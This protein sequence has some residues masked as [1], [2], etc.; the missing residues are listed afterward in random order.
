MRGTTPLPTVGKPLNGRQGRRRRRS[1]RTRGRPPQQGGWNRGDRGGFRHDQG[2]DYATQ[3][4]QLER[5]DAPIA[6]Y[7]PR[8]RATIGEIHW[9]FRDKRLI[10]TVTKL[11]LKQYA[12]SPFLTGPIHFP[13]PIDVPGLYD[14]S[15]GIQGS[16]QTV[17]A[18][19]RAKHV[20]AFLEDCSLDIEVRN[21]FNGDEF[22]LHIEGLRR[23]Q[24]RRARKILAD[25]SVL[26]DRTEIALPRDDRFTLEKLPTLTPAERAALEAHLPPEP[27]DVAGMAPDDSAEED[28]STS[29]AEFGV[30]E[31]S[32]RLPERPLR[33]LDDD[34]DQ[35][36]PPFER[37]TPPAV[38]VAPVD[39]FGRPLRPSMQGPR[40]SRG[41]DTPRPAQEG[42]SRGAR[43]FSASHSRLPV[44]PP[45]EARRQPP[46]PAHSARHDPDPLP[47]EPGLSPAS[48]LPATPSTLEQTKPLK[49]VRPTTKATP[50]AKRGPSAKITKPQ[51]AKPSKPAANVRT[52]KKKAAQKKKPATR[53]KKA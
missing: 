26:V 20:L 12:A 17:G 5:Q 48:R 11:R 29:S 44:P 40:Q 43:P 47:T 7:V 13:E 24:S 25:G 46:V 18:V 16:H 19:S 15:M 1:G 50:V 35:R 39:D 36:H 30:H 23:D 37:S 52:V 14:L 53:S 2:R 33:P 42:A 3:L 49:R 27:E 8:T 9:R 32:R 45:P 10:T 21:E 38:P 4:E 28:H 22:R 31:S 6:T 34:Q 51:R 41:R